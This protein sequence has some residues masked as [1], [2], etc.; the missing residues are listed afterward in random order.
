MYNYAHNQDESGKTNLTGAKAELEALEISS[1]EK[2]AAVRKKVESVREVY[3]RERLEAQNEAVWYRA[4]SAI[5]MCDWFL[6]EFCEAEAA[7]PEAE[8][9][10]K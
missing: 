7:A 8:R 1:K 2:L 10:T 5:R 4:D 3:M 6:R 9:E